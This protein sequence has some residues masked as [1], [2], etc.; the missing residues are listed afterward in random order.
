MCACMGFPM[1]CSDKRGS[2]EKLS[3]NLSCATKLMELIN[4]FFV[5]SNLNFIAKFR[6]KKN[7]LM[8]FFESYSE[9]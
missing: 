3:L 5:R 4:V 2:S 9:T 8:R 7:F 1:K 6:E